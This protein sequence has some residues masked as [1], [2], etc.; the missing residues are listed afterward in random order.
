VKQGRIIV[1]AAML[2]NCSR[3]AKTRAGQRTSASPLSDRPATGARRPASACGYVT[4]AEASSAL[5]QASG[6]RLES[7]G[8]TGHCVLVPVSGDAFH[9]ATVDYEV[10][11]GTTAY[12]FLAAQAQAQPLSGLGDKAL[13]LSA[14]RFRGNLAVIKG[15][16]VLSLTISDFRSGSDLRARARAL[17]EHVLE[18][19]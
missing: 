1:L 17:A 5:G 16:D 7:P 8:P 12:D 18:R 2:L 3:E 11:H 13:W 9:G 15:S 14:G 6:Y 10:S 19:L 4:A